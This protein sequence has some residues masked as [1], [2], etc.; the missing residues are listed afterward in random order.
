M[1][2]V[3]C[4]SWLALR[5]ATGTSA[6]PPSSVWATLGLVPVN[7]ICLVLVRKY[8][9]EL[10]LGLREAL[11]VRRGRLERDVLWGLL[12]LCVLNIPF[13]LAVGATVFALYGPAAPRAVETIFFDASAQSPL[14]AVPLLVLSPV[15]IVPFM[16]I[17]APTEELVFRGYALTGLTRAWGAPAGKLVTSGVFGAQ[18]IVF[19]AT[20]PG[21][22]VYFV[23]FTA[24]GLTASL[25]VRLQGRPLPVA[26]AHWITIIMLSAPGIVFPILMLVG[27]V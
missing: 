10:G 4:V 17:N 9:R 3:A 18:H 2:L 13:T 22:L 14:A 6:F 16:L 11:G 1:R 24:W 21:M 12:W 20:P 15:A 19:A 23:A 27:V 26:I 7:L 8:Y 25:I 5:V